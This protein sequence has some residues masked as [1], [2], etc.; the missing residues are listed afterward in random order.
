MI[1]VENLTKE[2]PLSRKQRKEL[3]D[4]FKNVKLICA[5]DNI[6]FDIYTSFVWQG[7]TR[8]L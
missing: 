8:Y 3:G 1:K 5:V 7:Q 4:E 2:F 6:S